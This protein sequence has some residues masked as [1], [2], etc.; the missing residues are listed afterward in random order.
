MQQKSKPDYEKLRV[1]LEKELGR[2]IT[3]EYAVEIGNK[4][5]NIYD[6]LLYEIEAEKNNGKIYVDTT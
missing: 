4:L 5:L 2:E 1:L 3:L 6:I